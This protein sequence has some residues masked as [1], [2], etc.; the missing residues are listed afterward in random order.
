MIYGRYVQ[1]GKPL[2]TDKKEPIT[3][4]TNEEPPSAAPSTPD[5]EIALGLHHND[6]NLVV[7]FAENDLEAW[8]DFIPPLGEGQPLKADSIAAIL[9][10]L[11]ITY[12]ID[13]ELI[14][15]SSM[16]CNL[17]HRTIKNVRIARGD[18][19]EEE[20]PAYFEI[21][22]SFRKWPPLPDGDVPRIDWKELSPF[23]IV[24]KGQVLARQR[25][26]KKGKEGKNIHGLPIPKTLRAVESAV[27]G[28]NTRVENGAI[29]AARDGRLLEKGKE[30][31]VE[32][33]LEVK[34][35]VD[36]ATGNIV[37]PGDV[38]IDG[39]VADGFKIYSG[40]SIVSKQTL[41][42]TDVNA[43]KDLIV[44]GGLIGRGKASIKVG[45]TLRTKFIQNCKVACRGKI[46]VGATIINSQIYTLDS[47]D[48]GDKGRIVGG[49]IY[50]V[51][52]LKTGSIGKE[53]GNGTKIHCGV[54]FT[55]QQRLDRQNENLRLLSS[56]IAKLREFLQGL[57]P[58][59]GDFKKATALLE[60]LKKE[61]NT[62]SNTIV[63]LLNRLNADEQAVIE[64]FG[65][66]VPGT[67]I[68]ICHIAYFVDTTL[69]RVRFRLDK[70]QGKLVHQSL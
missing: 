33:V 9:E 23:I 36:Y 65:E 54:D 18:P 51:R 5:Q 67:L 52:G 25:P 2:E 6:G 38:I 46:S 15:K 19:P 30:L 34:G 47:L 20:V 63:D 62:C 7:R 13:W 26:S 68:E 66:V 60:E 49:E 31:N 39:L 69:K 4:E 44:A 10:R 59:A 8:A 50:A 48:L 29:V 21:D 40:G 28:L 45:G 58:E 14:L 64:V 41:D 16:D 12:G 57:S 42:A 70:N 24:K 22:P 32:E 27:A 3:P 37:F 11:N 53:K 61:Q 17:D 1:W 56:K 55:A 35:S 43:K